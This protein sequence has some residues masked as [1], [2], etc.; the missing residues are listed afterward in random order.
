[1]SYWNEQKGVTLVELLIGI[2]IMAIIIGGIYACFYT[3]LQAQTY[4]FAKGRSIQD[5][6]NAINQIGRELEYA[7][8]SSIGVMVGGQYEAPG[9]SNSNGQYDLDLLTTAINTNEIFFSVLSST[10]GVKETRHIYLLNNNIV[11]DIGNYPQLTTPWTVTSSVTLA[12]GSAQ[13]LSFVIDKLD[14]TASSIYNDADV[15]AAGVGMK[16]KKITIVVT[17]N[18][19]PTNAAKPADTTDPRLSVFTTTVVTGNM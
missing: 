8:G 5:G 17:T 13:N 18:D 9:D 6:S 14:T 11:I 1:M 12:P 10:T 19:H 16:R 2:A 15:T 4:G 3:S 7:Y